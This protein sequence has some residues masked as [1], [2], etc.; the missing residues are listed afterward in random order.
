MAGRVLAV[1]DL[2][3]TGLYNSDRVVEIGVVRL[4]TDGNRIS[5]FTTLVN[6]MRDVGPTSL[7]GITA[8]MVAQAPTFPEIAATLAAHL[9]GAV[10][11]AHNSTFDQRM[12]T[13]EVDRLDTAWDLG[14]PVCTMSWGAQTFGAGRSLAD[15]CEAARISNR[16]PHSAV[17]DARATAE[18]L[19]RC[20]QLGID[21]DRCRRAEA[22][23]TR[24][25]A[26]WPT[27]P[28]TW[29]RTSDFIPEPSYLAALVG[30]VH[31]G[32]SADQAYLALL[33]EVLADHRVTEAEASAL[34]LLARE[35]GYTPSQVASL[36][37]EYLDA[38]IDAALRDDLVAD[39]EMAVL[40]SAAVALGAQPSRV[41]TRVRDFR[42][43]TT[44][45]VTSLAGTKV[46]FTG[47]WPGEYQGEPWSQELGEELVA[48][49]GGT[50]VP[51]VTKRTQLLVAA[52]TASMSGKARKARQ[53][54]IPVISVPELIELIDL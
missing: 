12:L 42:P 47:D 34:A 30:Q 13:N 50:P 22:I 52:D 19:L 38:L 53:Y 1:V 4:D 24:I 28:R 49:A 21:D 37:E 33:D 39:E 8:S 18:L 44:P 20:L 15:C 32:G 25:D 16:H 40:S 36:H 29:R 23:T 46:C 7:H 14:T 3:T 51:S 31:A 45:R 54:A 11:V 9:H 10:F 6:P 48:A 35:C 41:D 27:L 5:E 17:D 43:A 2:E 26:S